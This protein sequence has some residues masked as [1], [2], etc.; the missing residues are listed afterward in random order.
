[1]SRR[2][3]WL[4]GLVLGAMACAHPAPTTEVSSAPTTSCATAVRPPE[5]WDRKDLDKPL[6]IVKPGP[7][8]A[9]PAECRHAGC[10]AEAV[11]DFIILAT[12]KV[13]PCSIQIA[14][15]IPTDFGKS[16]AA[17]FALT[18]YDPPLRHGSP[19]AAQVR[20]SLKMQVLSKRSARRRSRSAGR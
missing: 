11:L 14:W 8:P 6:H 7:V 10:N 20:D 9:T 1:M 5:V 2:V 13:D 4:P 18:I 16:A 15:A 3:G 17:S 19:V 12:G